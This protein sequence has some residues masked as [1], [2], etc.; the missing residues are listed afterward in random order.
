MKNTI[1]KTCA[2]LT[3]L[4]LVLSGTLMNVQAENVKAPSIPK[5]VIVW[6]D[7]KSS[8]YKE[9]GSSC[10]TI[11][12]AVKSI[13]LNG[14]GA[15]DKKGTLNIPTSNKKFTILYT[16]GFRYNAFNISKADNVKVTNALIGQ[17][18]TAKFDIT[19]NNRTYH[20]STKFVAKKN[21]GRYSYIKV[22]G[23]NILKKFKEDVAGDFDYSMK[24]AGKKVTIN[25][26]ANYPNRNPGLFLD[27]GNKEY[28]L[29]NKKSFSVKKGDYI[30]FVITPPTWDREVS[31]ALKVK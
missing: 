27:R 22:N 29:K 17:K 1:T 5:K 18:G 8:K 4:S 28:K 20:M 9:C 16:K 10:Q 23:K 26:K 30:C 6:V 12:N 31:Y 25:Y 15:I 14:T 3:S 13:E 24:L 19:Q 21:P 7:T 2:T 11:K